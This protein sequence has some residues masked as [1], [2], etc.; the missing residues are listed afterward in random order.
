MLHANN[1]SR[2]FD[3]LEGGLVVLAAYQEMQQSGDMTA[4]FLQES[5]FWWATGIEEP[6]WRVIL[7]GT[8][9]R[10]T[11]VRP[12]RSQLDIVFYGESSDDAIR[13]MSG[14]DTIIDAQD[15][16]HELRQLRRQHVMVQTVDN[17]HTGEG[18]VSNPAQAELREVLERIFHSVQDCGS[19][20]AA[21]KAIKQP[22]EITRMRQAIAVT[23]QAFEHV[24]GTLKSYKSENEIEAEFT[25]RFRRANATHAYAPIVAGGK[26]ACT[27]HYGANSEKVGSRE[28]ILIDIGARYMGYSAD[29]TRTYCRNPTKRQRAVHAAVERA[30]QAII[31]LIEP[32]LLIQDYIT[33]S[34]D[35]MRGALRELGL[36]KDDSDTEAFR[37]YFPHAISHGLGIDTHDSLG[38]PRYF[39]P[40]MVLTVE[41]GIYIPEEGIG[42]RIEDDILVTTTG[43]ENLSQGLSTAIDH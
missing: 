10:A 17:K 25:Y 26:N 32:G 35:I 21:L 8:R 15:F 9:R 3:V 40:G 18:V 27:L 30:Q 34:D 7:D 37:R 33:K 36:V 6:G 11:L 14:I 1:R 23:T 39:E 22:E 43:H 19:A 13:A 38:A 24:I 20:F 41:P 31:A 5:S 28:M 29:I 4:P 42:V 12:H 2:L 16:E